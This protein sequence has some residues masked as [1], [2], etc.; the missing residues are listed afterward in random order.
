M[1]L[2]KNGKVKNKKKRQRTNYS[3]LKGRRTHETSFRCNDQS[4]GLCCHGNFGP[5]TYAKKKN[6]LHITQH[7]LDGNPHVENDA[8][9]S[10]RFLAAHWTEDTKSTRNG[11]RF[12]VIRW[13]IGEERWIMV[14]GGESYRD[15]LY[16]NPL[17]CFFKKTVPP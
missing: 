13:I 12:T 2:R 6:E 7:L 17:P 11:G 1:H 3:L 15:K 4:I 10:A 5:N 8:I 9:L 14:H 16:S